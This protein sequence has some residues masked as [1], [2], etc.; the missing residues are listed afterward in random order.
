MISTYGV[1]K[2]KYNIKTVKTQTLEVKESL[3]GRK[4][5]VQ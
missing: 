3:F 2:N 4:R 1:G 5:R